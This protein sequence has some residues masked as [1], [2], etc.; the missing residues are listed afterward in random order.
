VST[1]LGFVAF[2]L[3]TALM[4][5]AAP[6]AAGL[7]RW[8][9]GR[10]LGRAGPPPWQPWL[11][12][13][14]L[15]RKQPVF[16]ENA[17]FVFRWAPGVVFAATLAAAA[18]VPSFA[19]HMT[20]API[21][22][23]IVLA[24]LL[25]LG[26]AALALAAMDVGTAFGGIGAS[27]EMTFAAYAEPALVL[28]LTIFTF[29]LL[30][31]TTNLDALAAQLHDF[32]FGLRVSLGLALLSL[33]GVALAD[34]G[35]LPVDNPASHL[36]LAMV[37]EAMVL[38]YSG[39]PL[40]LLELSACL[41]LL[42]WMTLIGTLFAPFGLGPADAGPAGWLAGLLGWAFRVVVLS[43][44]LALL[45]ST[46]AKMRVFRV[47]EFLGVAVLLAL[48]AVVFLFVSQGFA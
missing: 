37:H 48:L 8:L 27:R 46:L 4:L 2:V 44:A 3:H 12:I 35:R 47:P 45:E 7:V 32:A 36:E 30:A 43:A 31:S 24:G 5:A 21:A 11:E 20:T 34:S 16:A 28:V 9:K 25:S 29:A 40:A 22:D 38:E 17:S 15:S 14:R 41:R 6:V 33:L 26:R 42:L 10:L 23:L 18:L 1:A 19:L 39:P 13:V